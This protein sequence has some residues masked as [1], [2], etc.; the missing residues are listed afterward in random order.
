MRTATVILAFTLTVGAASSAADAPPPPPL[1]KATKEFS[2]ATIK[3]HMEVRD[4]AITQK[5]RKLSLVLIV[6]FGTTEARARVLGDNFVRLVKTFSKEEQAPG[7][8]IGAGVYDYFIGV[9]DPNE[10][11][12]ALGAKVDFARR[13]TW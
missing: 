10:R 2:L 7:K 13:I 4:A 6:N 3:Q 11:E 8:D 5:G 9:Y 1:T 12:I